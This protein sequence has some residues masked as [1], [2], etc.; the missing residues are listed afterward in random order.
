M[1]QD[2]VALGSNEDSPKLSSRRPL[3]HNNV[4]VCRRCGRFYATKTF[5]RHQRRCL[6]KDDTTYGSVQSMCHCLMK[7]MKMKTSPNNILA[8]FCDDDVSR[9]CKSDTTLKKVGLA[10]WQKQKH[11]QGKRTEV[12][13]SVMQD[14]RRLHYFTNT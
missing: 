14:M 5:Y 11:K 13:K 10:L 6:S 8:K 3:V 9:L 4:V 2:K 7:T 1:S 12:H